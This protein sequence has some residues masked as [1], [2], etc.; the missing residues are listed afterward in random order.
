MS[1]LGESVYGAVVKSD[2]AGMEVA[3]QSGRRRFTAADI[4]S[5]TVE[6]P[7]SIWNGVLYGVLVGAAFDVATA[8]KARNRHEENNLLGLGTFNGA[9]WGGVIDRARRRKEV[10]FVAGRGRLG[11]SL[12]IRW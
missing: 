9:L 7:D 5:L 6:V 12:H 11:A 10:I 3:T 8:L 4:Q 2:A 1:V